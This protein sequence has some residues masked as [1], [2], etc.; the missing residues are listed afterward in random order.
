MSGPLPN[1]T[2]PHAEVLL[3]GNSPVINLIIHAPKWGAFR[4]ADDK[5]VIGCL[6]SPGVPQYAVV[7]VYAGKGIGERCA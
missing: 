4:Y 5:S 6:I 2:C 1:C 3:N 7:Y